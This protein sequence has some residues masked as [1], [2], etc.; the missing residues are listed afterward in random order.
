M[1]P[2]D[3]A[4][5]GD[6]VSTLVI[7]DKEEEAASASGRPT[8]ARPRWDAPAAAAASAP[9]NPA[10]QRARDGDGAEASG[11]TDRPTSARPRWAAPSTG[12]PSARPAFAVAGEITVVDLRDTLAK[13]VF[14]SFT[15]IK[16]TKY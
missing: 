5:A 1:P 3:I 2:L 6:T 16:R 4:G 11:S 13:K 8:S 15:C 7:E 14:M 12:E 9:A 10:D